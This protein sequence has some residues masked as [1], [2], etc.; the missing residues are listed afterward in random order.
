METRNTNKGKIMNIDE[1]KELVAIFEDSSLNKIELSKDGFSIA[2]ERGLGGGVVTLPTASFA[3]QMEQATQATAE[4]PKTVACDSIK[5]PMVGTFYRCASPDSPPYV[6]VGD[7]V[8]K[9]QT[10]AIIEAMKIMNEIEADFDCKI[11][12]V[13]PEDGHPVE[14]GSPLFKVERI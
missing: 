10:V 1:I 9:G 7:T 2:L 11:I 14:Y 5:S 6:K 3:T 13:V 8:R 4:V 12:D